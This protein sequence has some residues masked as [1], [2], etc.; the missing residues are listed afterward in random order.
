[1]TDETHGPIEG[2]ARTGKPYLKL[3][4]VGAVAVAILAL[5]VLG[6]RPPDRPHATPSP[7][8]LA[9]DPAAT[10]I[11]RPP[12]SPTPNLNLEPP[13][14]PDLAG[15]ANANLAPA[16]V[17][18]SLLEDSISS[19]SLAAIGTRIFYAVDED[20]IKSAAIGSDAVPQTLVS[21]SGCQSINQVTAAGYLVGYVETSPAGPPLDASGCGTFTSVAWSIWL[22]DLSGRIRRLVAAGVAPVSSADIGVYPVHLA[23]T[24]ST[25]AYNVPSGR[26]RA[27]GGQRV[28]VHSTDDLRLL[29][30]TQTDG[31]VSAVMLGGNRLAVMTDGLRLSTKPPEL[32]IADSSQTQLSKVAQPVSS[33]A[34]SADGTYLVWDANTAAGKLPAARE[35]ELIV[36][37]IGSRTVQDVA[38]PVSISSPEPLRPI[39]S[40]SQAGPILAWYGTAPEDWIYPIFRDPA[41][42]KNVPLSDLGTTTWIGLQGS[43]LIWIVAD[44]AG[45]QDH[46]FAVDLAHSGFAAASA[47]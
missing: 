33:A 39:I 45:G 13:A 35:S 32:W 40:S 27:S 6:P 17:R 25:Y 12:P 42:Q 34:L 23:L 22:S 21:V 16:D 31:P 18:Q 41:N 28:E 36:E 20:T 7:P 11:P 2:W 46:A 14:V 1:M 26:G 24:A 15:L 29:W 4:V 30:A 3:G 8:L 9:V 19:F 10:A 38:V 44:P 37:M 47:G 5:G 43:V